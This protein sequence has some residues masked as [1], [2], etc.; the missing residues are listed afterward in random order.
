MPPLILTPLEYTQVCSNDPPTREFLVELVRRMH[1]QQLIQ[2]CAGISYLSWRQGIE[3]LAHQN[4][5]AENLVR[6]LFYGPAIIRRLRHEP[7]YRLCTREGLFALLR[8]AF[9]EKSE[10]DDSFDFADSFVRANLAVNQLINAETLVDAPTGGAS[11]LL[12][13][14]LRSEIQ[15][16]ENFHDLIGRTHALFEWSDSEAGRNSKNALPLKDDLRRFTGLTPL[17]YG[18]A[19]YSIVSRSTGFKKWDD[20]ESVPLWLK[21]EQMGQFTDS[22]PMQKWLDACSVPIEEACETWAQEPSLSLAAVG[23]LWSKPVLRD[24]EF[25]MIPYAP[26]ATN[27]MGD[28]TYFSLLHGYGSDDD[29]EEKKKQFMTL[30][31]E[32]FEDYVVDVLTRAYGDRQD[33][34]FTPEIIYG[35][36]ELRSSDFIVQEGDDII[37]FEIVAKR[38][39]MTGSV[40][41]FS[42]Q[43]IATDLELGV[44]CKIRQIHDNIQRFRERTLLPEWPRNA[45]QRF[46]PVLVAPHERPR[47]YVIKEILPKLMQDEH[48]LDGCEPIE[49]LDVGEVESLEGALKSGSRL[50]ALLDRK[51]S[52]PAPATRFWSL[53]NYLVEME[54]TFLPQGPSLAR[55][56]GGQAAKEMVSLATSW[57]KE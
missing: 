12:R 42:A 44:S 28:E 37:F 34:R 14:E 24:G 15:Q 19:A 13:S 30:Y 27:T 32:F 54:Q 2:R 8:L 47:I 40:L 5:L 11:D 25:Y 29:D 31:G 36:P 35:E 46:F 48:F 49:F 51:N 21:L 57:L 4:N 6:S 26:L 33:I 23:P 56:R 20:V 9:I 41:N 53:H 10:G 38:M 1:W 43:S 55:E 18:A 17:E 22:T 3:N 50:G 39:N 16:L 52:G 7:Q 45:S